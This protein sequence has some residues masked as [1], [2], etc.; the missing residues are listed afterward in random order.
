M[1]HQQIW[2][3]AFIQILKIKSISMRTIIVLRHKIWMKTNHSCKKNKEIP[4]W[5]YVLMDK[6]PMDHCPDGRLSGWTIVRMDDCPDG[7]LSG[8]TIVLF[9]LKL[10]RLGSGWIDRIVIIRL[11][12][13]N[14]S[15][16]IQL[17]LSLAIY[18]KA[19]V[20]YAYLQSFKSA[21]L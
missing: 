5:T 6:C 18:D 21:I 17:E 7:R 12:Q 16:N 8:W 2:L 9:P 14:C 19:C 20:G 11:S 15:C 1:S 10:F 3:F 4:F 13:F